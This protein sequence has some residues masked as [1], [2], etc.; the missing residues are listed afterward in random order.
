[1]IKLPK[2]AELILNNL[3]SKGF[4]AYIVGGAVR[5]AVLGV[6]PIDFDIATSA[7]PKEIQ[8][9]FKNTINIGIKHGTVGVII[10]NKIYEVTTFR[11]EGS[12]KDFRRPENVS[13]VD[14]LHLDL[15]RRDFTVNAMAYSP[16]AG[17]IDPFGGIN[18]IKSKTIKTVGDPN[19]R[20]Y[21]DA[22]RMLRAIRFCAVL[23]FSLEK[24]T[25]DAIKNNSA[26]IKN[27]SAE[28]I[29]QELEKILLSDRPG[30][31][32]LLKTTNLLD[33]IIPE[34]SKCFDTP[35][36]NLYHTAD[37]GTHSIMAVENAPKN[38]I[39]RWAALLH[40]IGK[41]YTKS[42]DKKGEHH[43]YNH[44]ICS[45][46][47]ARKILNNLK[48]SN[49]QKA[50]ILTLIKYHDYTITPTPKSVKKAVRLV[51]KDLFLP[52]LELKRADCLSH[53]PKLIKNGIELLDEIKKIYITIINAKDA[54]DK[55]DLA[56]DGHDLIAAGFLPNKEL[57]SVLDIL[58]LMVTEKPELNKKD[59][60]I[61]LALK[62]KKLKI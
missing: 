34:L 8:S 58:V 16:K 46:D 14:D 41:L 22:L 45:Y 54:I 44:P 35:Q 43:F 39:L 37:V 33:Y 3:N 62:I 1:M 51:G 40:D 26:L 23:D 32:S 60:L 7:K 21:E 15:S 25:L 48:F 57:G 56:I 50:N 53:N 4:S 38:S 24:N 12:Y 18:D 59:I 11:T 31:I 5:S 49:K 20:F 10:D 52:L 55:S 42:E 13:F 2:Q 27:I 9:I 30:Y 47:S 17:I 6:E 19:K 36:N 28:R 29:H 61:S